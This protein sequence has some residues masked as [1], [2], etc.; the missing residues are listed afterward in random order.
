M[1]HVVFPNILR[2]KIECEE[3][4]KIRREILSV[5]HNIVMNLN[6]VM[7]YMIITDLNTICLGYL[8]YISNV[9]GG[10]MPRGGV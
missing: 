10:P 3:Y 8:E 9:G 4:S 7:S 5:P 1:F 6:N 2:I